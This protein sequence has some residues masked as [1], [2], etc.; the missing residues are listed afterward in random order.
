MDETAKKEASLKPERVLSCGRDRRERGRRSSV[1]PFFE[2]GHERYSISFN[3]SKA[4]LNF[5][6]Y[7]G[8]L[9]TNQICPTR[10]YRAIFRKSPESTCFL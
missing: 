2:L 7:L 10:R 3:S 5:L 1:P 8:I 9:P 4:S 6:P